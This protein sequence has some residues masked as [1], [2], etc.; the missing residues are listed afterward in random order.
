MKKYLLIRVDGSEGLG[1]G[2]VMRCIGLASELKSQNIQPIFLCQNDGLVLKKIRA[3]GF[4]VKPI[5]KKDGF[6][7]QT[8]IIIRAAKKYNTGCIVF[9]LNNSQTLSKLSQY[10][11]H[12]NL[13]KNAGNK[14]IIIEGL[15][16]ENIA[17]KVKL[18]ADMIIAPYYLADKAKYITRNNTKLLLGA[19]YF[20]FRQEFIKL[21]NRKKV[22]PKRAKNILVSLGG[23]DVSVPNQKVLKALTNI[24]TEKGVKIKLAPGSVN[25]ARLIHWADIAIIG[26]GLTKYE[27]ALM[28][29]P[30]I[31]TSINSVQSESMKGFDEGGTAINLG[32]INKISIQNIDGAVNHL[33]LDHKQRQKMKVAGQKLVDG[34]GAARIVSQIL[35]MIV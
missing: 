23:G 33:V 31:I 15:G 18:S 10:A 35:K 16:K 14:L 1:M 22:I 12:I 5:F 20:V 4:I 27:A 19:K 34:Q 8:S 7:K 9:D 24:K 30:S 26:G 28:G 6:R 3:L 32:Q 13:L 29:T 11:N 17:S 21:S 25:M 2:H